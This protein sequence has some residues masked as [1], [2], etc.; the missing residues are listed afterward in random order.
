[1]PDPTRHDQK[2]RLVWD[3]HDFSQHLMSAGSTKN[4]KNAETWQEQQAMLPNI[5][6]WKSLR[7]EDQQNL[8]PQVVEHLLTNTKKRRYKVMFIQTFC[9][10][11]SFYLIANDN[12]GGYNHI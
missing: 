3:T 8:K 9:F 12:K 4:H 7:D 2:S 10:H 11:Q 6:D 1:M 5:I